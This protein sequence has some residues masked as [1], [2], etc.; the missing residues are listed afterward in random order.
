M[1]RFKRKVSKWHLAARGALVVSLMGATG[2]AG[3][4]LSPKPP[5]CRSLDNLGFA[6]A[7]PDGIHLYNMEICEDGALRLVPDKVVPMKE[8]SEFPN[9]SGEPKVDI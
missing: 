7:Q 6:Y 3:F 9:D 5:R 1:A 2:A 4:F 8:E